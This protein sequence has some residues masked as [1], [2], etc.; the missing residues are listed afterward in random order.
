MWVRHARI[1]AVFQNPDTFTQFAV[2]VQHQVS[3]LFGSGVASTGVAVDS[4][5]FAGDQLLKVGL[6]MTEELA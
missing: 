3:D 1:S 4:I 2:P 6:E 5:I